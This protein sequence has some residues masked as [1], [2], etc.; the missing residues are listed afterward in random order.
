[1]PRNIKI[2]VIVCLLA[3]VLVFLLT[4]YRISRNNPSAELSPEQLRETGALVY[5]RPVELS[6]FRLEDH[7]GQPYTQESLRGKWSLIFFGFTNCPDICPLTMHELRRFYTSEQATP[8][9]D[10]TEVVLVSVDPFRDTPARVGAYA[11]GFHQDFV[12][13]TGEYSEISRLA[14]QLY[15]AHSEP[16]PDDGPDYMVDHSGNILIIN[17][18]GQYHGFMESSIKGENI[19]RAYDSIRKTYR[20]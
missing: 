20:R 18:A 12:G 7:R 11:A 4:Y 10:D 3:V 2:T 5:D 16:A 14:R 13:V 17:P 9:R 1:M 6:P 8:W 19:A 15:V